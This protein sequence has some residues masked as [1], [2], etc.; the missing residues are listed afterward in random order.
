MAKV[1][2]LVIGYDELAS[3]VLEKLCG[4]INLCAII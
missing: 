3:N 2:V 1:I 4:R